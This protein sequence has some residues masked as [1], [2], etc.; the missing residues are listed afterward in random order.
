MP[1]QISPIQS[2]W[3]QDVLIALTTNVNLANPI[4]PEVGGGFDPV[5]MRMLLTG[6]TA[7]AQNGIYHLVESGEDLIAERAPDAAAAGDF[8]PAKAVRVRELQFKGAIFVNQST[9]ATLGTTAIS[10]FRPT[11]AVSELA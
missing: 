4:S 7:P 1:P 8:V 5:G 3:F 9:V 10:F 6:Q 2:D 11:P